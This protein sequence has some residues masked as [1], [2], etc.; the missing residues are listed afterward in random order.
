MRVLSRRGFTL[1][2]LMIALLLL[3]IVATGIYRVLVGNQQTD[4][5]QTQR[6]DLQQNIRAVLTI[7]P[8]DFREI[9]AADGDI[10]KM[11]CT[12]LTIRARRSLAFI[13]IPPGPGGRLGGITVTLR[14]Q[15]IFGS[16]GR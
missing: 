9:A 7:L 4:L 13:C 14:Q 11:A 5:A 3:G 6:I 2:E 10:L 12:S 8:A 16:P 15:Q 1:I